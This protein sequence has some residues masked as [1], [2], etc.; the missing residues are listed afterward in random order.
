MLYK[1][2]LC[3]IDNAAENALQVFFLY[4]IIFTAYREANQRDESY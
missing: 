2:I 3:T 1:N 4:N